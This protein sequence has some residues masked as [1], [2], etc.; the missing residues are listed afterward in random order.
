M[1][2]EFVSP[3]NHSPQTGI[4]RYVHTLMKRLRQEVDVSIGEPRFLPL[5]NRFSSMRNLPVGIKNHV[6]G[7]IVHFPQIMGCAMMLWRPYYPSVATVHDLGV[8]ELP[9]EWEMLDLIARQLLRASLTGL[10]RVD[11]IVADSEFTRQGVI[12]HLNIPPERVVT[13]Y[14]GIDHKV[15]HPIENARRKLLQRYPELQP[16]AASPWLL[17]VGSELPRKNV[18]TLLRA[19][20]LLQR[21]IPD[22]RLLKV[23]SAGGDVYRRKT[24]RVVKGLGLDGHIIFFDQV[25]EQD[26]PIFYSAVDLF[27]T[28]SKLE[29]F[30]FP[31][32]EAMACGT[33][34]VCS[35]TTAL[36]EI[37]GGA[38]ILV[39]PEDHLSLYKSIRDGLLDEPLSMTLKQK[40]ISRASEF[41]WEI[42]PRL[43]LDVYIRTMKINQ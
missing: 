20:A 36:A 25:P 2:V 29:G 6:Q 11:L 1:R 35:S 4:G 13:I 23:G 43:L 38:A 14:P 41:D 37:A 31:V 18:G 15:F 5:T 10:K 26:L 22:V 21:A 42:T 33:P 39:E 8:L 24:L 7:S 12:K 27:V 34:V 9:E 3:Y 28:A 40:G 30:G 19:L 16:H 32:L 17:Y